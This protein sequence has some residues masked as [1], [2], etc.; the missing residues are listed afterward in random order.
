MI[1][2]SST[3]KRGINVE[4]KKRIEGANGESRESESKRGNFKTE[5]ESC[6]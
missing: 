1:S 3:L 2:L 4:D 5:I 6:R